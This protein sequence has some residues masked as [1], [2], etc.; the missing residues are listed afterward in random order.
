MLY[1]ANGKT[2]KNNKLIEKYTEINKDNSSSIMNKLNTAG[3]FF[4]NLDDKSNI[5]INTNNNKYKPNI[6]FTDKINNKEANINFDAE[7]DDKT[8]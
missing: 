5:N 7:L 3:L 2:K 8:N 4:N 1:T 6:K